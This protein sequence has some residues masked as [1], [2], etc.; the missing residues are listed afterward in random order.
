M[1]LARVNGKQGLC[2][3]ARA[4]ECQTKACGLCPGLVGGGCG[5]WSLLEVVKPAR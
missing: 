2:L 3:A 4:L 5:H 1:G